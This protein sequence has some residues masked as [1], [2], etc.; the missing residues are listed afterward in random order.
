MIGTPAVLQKGSE[1]V[2]YYSNRMSHVQLYTLMSMVHG[3]GQLK[4]CSLTAQVLTVQVRG[5]TPCSKIQGVGRDF[6]L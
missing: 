2:V 4:L 6:L 1:K 3:F 5:G